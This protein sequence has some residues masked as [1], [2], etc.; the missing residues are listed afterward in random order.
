MLTHFTVLI[1]DNIL[2]A[3]SRKT[4]RRNARRGTSWGAST[5]FN[6]DLSTQNLLPRHPYSRNTSRSPSRS[7]PLSRVSSPAIPPLSRTQTQMSFP[8]HAIPTTGHHHC[9]RSDADETG[10]TIFDFAQPA[11]SGSYAFSDV[12]QIG[13]AMSPPLPEHDPNRGLD[14]K[15]KRKARER[16][17]HE[18]DEWSDEQ[19]SDREDLQVLG[20]ARTS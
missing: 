5:V 7:A 13:L 18:V 2:L 10:H 16:R 8:S 3:L 9:D 19:R 14:C 11:P 6:A 20:R 4:S 12:G 15:G 1:L 17:D